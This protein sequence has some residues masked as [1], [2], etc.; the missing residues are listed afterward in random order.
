[1]VFASTCINGNN[2]VHVPAPIGNIA[3]LYLTR[4]RETSWCQLCRNDKVVVMTTLG[5]QCR[6]STEVIMYR[7]LRPLAIWQGVDC[8][9]SFHPLQLS[10]FSAIYGNLSNNTVGVCQNRVYS[11]CHEHK[12]PLSL[13]SQYH[14]CWCSGDATSKGISNRDIYYVEA[15]EI[16]PGHV[17]GQEATQFKRSSGQFSVCVYLVWEQPKLPN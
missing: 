7:Y 9:K 11:S 10:G 6:V 1:M 13:H 5:F 4:Y 16:G 12:D 17:Q 3:G 14:G 2:H 8:W 15:S